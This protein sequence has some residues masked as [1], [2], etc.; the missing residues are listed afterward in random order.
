MR[1]WLALGLLALLSPALV[2]AD[3]PELAGKSE[4]LFGVRNAT[5]AQVREAGVSWC[6]GPVIAWGMI[7]PRRGSCNW[8]ELDRAINSA[9]EAGIQLIP[10]LACSSPWGCGPEVAW[11]GNNP[12]ALRQ[13]GYPQEERAWRRFVCAVVERYDGDGVDDAP[14][15]VRPIK[16]WQMER[17][18]PRTWVGKPAQLVSYLRMTREAIKATDARATVVVGGL[19]PNALY[20]CALADKAI[21]ELSLRGRPVD[22]A[23]L[24]QNPLFREQKALVEAVLGPAAPY[25]DVL[26]VHLYG[27]YASIPAVVGWLDGHP[28]VKGKPKWCLQ[29]GGPVEVFD[30]A[31]SEQDVANHVA[32]WY[33]MLAI[34]G[35]QRGAWTMLPEPGAEFNETALLQANG[36]KRLAFPAYRVAMARISGFTK[37]TVDSRPPGPMVVHFNGPSMNV[38]I[39]WSDAARAVDVSQLA[40][41]RVTDAE[42]KPVATRRGML[43]LG[44]APFFFE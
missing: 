2:A 41:K 39:A 29:G 14:R 4:P 25:Y 28:G 9:G 44:P 17:E 36:D 15:L 8:S 16:Y 6:P 31:A 10:I 24:A 20:A 40:I 26:D 21:P 33:T 43:D 27:R 5:L 34:A 37:V 11:T 18:L 12:R 42:G 7:E 1:F 13:S 38:H 30:G 23:S 19:A 32:K 22:R 3:N 35:V